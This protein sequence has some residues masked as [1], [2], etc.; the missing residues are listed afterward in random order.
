MFERNF[1]KLTIAPVE[2]VAGHVALRVPVEGDG[3]AFGE[4]LV[5]TE[6]DGRLLGAGLAQLVRGLKSAPV[7]GSWRRSVLRQWFMVE[8]SL[9]CFGAV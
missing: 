3:G 1:V 6:G 4:P 5:Q 7:V 2:E 8:N 9:C